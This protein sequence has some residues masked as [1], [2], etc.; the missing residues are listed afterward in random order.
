MACYQVSVQED[1]ENKRATEANQDI[2]PEFKP[3]Q[4]AGFEAALEEA[5][6]QMFASAFNAANHFAV[7]ATRPRPRSSLRSPRKI[8][9]PNGSPI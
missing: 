3:K 8:P 1:Q 2:D 6:R 7:A 4:I 9:L 5:S